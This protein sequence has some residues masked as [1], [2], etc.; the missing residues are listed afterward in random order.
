MG[1]KWPTLRMPCG[2][3]WDGL[4]DLRVPYIDRSE[5][6]VKVVNETS[7]GEF[8]GLLPPS[9]ELLHRTV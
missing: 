4:S 9:P 2:S 3:N 1:I 5:R 8:T 6:T 7:T